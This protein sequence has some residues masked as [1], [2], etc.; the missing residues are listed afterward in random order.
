MWVFFL[1]VIL[2][3]MNWWVFRR[4]VHPSWLIA[5]LGISFSI[6]VVLAKQLKLPD[7]AVGPILILSTAVTLSSFINRKFYVIGLLFASGIVF[8]V[9]RGTLVQDQ[10][11][12]Y[13]LYFNKQVTVIGVVNDDIDINNSGEAVIRLGD[14]HIDNKKLPGTVYITTDNIDAKRGDE[15]TIKGKLVNGFG[16]FAAKISGAKVIQ[17]TQPKPG[18]I[19]RVIRDWFANAIRKV[20]PD[21]EASLGIGFLVGQR[22]SL[23]ANLVIA[24]QAVGLTH[25]VVASGYNLTILV[26]LARRLFEK[27]SKYLAALSS[28]IMI[29]TFI[30]IAGSSPSM[31]RAGIVSGLG[32]LAWY[33]GR[34]FHPIVLLSLAVALTLIIDP[35]YAWGDLGWQLSFAAFAGVM[36]LAPLATKYFFGDKKPNFVGQLLIETVAAQIMTAPIIIFAFGQFSNV[37]VLTNL[38]VLPFVPIAM[39]LVFIAGISAVLLPLAAANYFAAPATWLLKYMT[40]VIDYFAG[41]DWSM[42]SLS[43]KWYLLPIGYALIIGLCLYF[44]RATK[45]NLWDSNLVE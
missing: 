24:L 11:S 34:K 9:W 36:I 42:V 32:I 40:G 23:P 21:P 22:R 28:A 6:G 44:W 4:R 7:N 38:L 27:V 10:L 1:G 14:I 26:R 35:S 20:I 18:D 15:L 29:L 30:A 39:L 5:A 17:I 16:N 12:L 43:P 19:A 2:I 45:Y 3:S 33:Y 31:I 25:I 8:G 37:A 41:F 13:N